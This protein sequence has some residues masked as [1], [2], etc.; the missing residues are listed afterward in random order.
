MRIEITQDH[1]A[2]VLARI[3]DGSASILSGLAGL[4]ETDARKLPTPLSPL[5]QEQRMAVLQRVS[6]SALARF[7]QSVVGFELLRSAGVD[8]ADPKFSELQ[9]VVRL[10]ERRLEQLESTTP[11]LQGLTAQ[12]KR[13]RRAGR[14]RVEQ[15]SAAFQGTALNIVGGLEPATEILLS[16]RPEEYVDVI[17]QLTA[18]GAIM[19]FAE[20]NGIR[21]QVQRSSSRVSSDQ[22]R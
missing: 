12:A 15:I 8:D 17:L 21:L 10:S 22:P 18:Q 5:E 2:S 6:Q 20:D 14:E 4:V 3:R 19:K 9:N 11:E 16:R 13:I 7:T 1:V